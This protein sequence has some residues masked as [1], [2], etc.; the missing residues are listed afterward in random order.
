MAIF[1]TCAGARGPKS[2]H[3]AERIAIGS[4]GLMVL[5]VANHQCH[6]AAH[7]NYIQQK[8]HCQNGPHSGLSASGRTN[9]HQPD[10]IPKRC[11][12]HREKQRLQ[13]LKPELAG[14]TYQRYAKSCQ[15]LR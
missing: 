1:S 6:P 3:T 7:H 4:T 15:D 14:R 12:R 11:D 9:P 5:P 8:T 10:L 2:S 13:M